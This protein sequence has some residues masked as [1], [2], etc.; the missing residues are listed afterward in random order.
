MS[1]LIY[2]LVIAY[3]LLSG[4]ALLAQSYSVRGTFFDKKT[5][6]V[7]PG[8]SVSILN[9]TDS[10]IVKGVS[11]DLNGQF[12]IQEVYP[13]AYILK[14][15]LIGLSP[16]YRS[17]QISSNNLTIGSIYLEL[18]ETQ[19]KTV[20]IEGTEIRV[21]QKGDTTEINAAAYQV[22]PDASVED[23]IKKMPG[24]TV[25]NGVVKAQGEEVKK[26]LI[27]G[28]EYFG[29]DA[30]S[31]VKNLPA[32]IVE[33]MQVFDK[34]SDQAQ[35]T[36]F[37][38]GNSLKTMNIVTKVGKRNGKFGKQTAGYGTNDRFATSFTY[39]A[40]KKTRKISVLGM[41]N[42]INQ[43]NFSS[44]DL[45]GVTSAAGSGGGGR[46]G[47]GG[48]VGPPTND[49]S[50]FSV[51][52]SNGINTTSS[53]GFNYNDSLN[54]YIKLTGSYFFNSTFNSTRKAINR[55][56][57]LDSSASQTYSEI[58]NGRANNL[59]HRVNLRVEF[60]LDSS[61]T[62]IF[63]PKVSWQGNQL[64]SSVTG[65]SK[66]SSGVHLS[67]TLNDN[68]KINSGYTVNTNLLFRHKFR[69]AGRTISLNTG[70]DASEKSGNNQLNSANEY[71]AQDTSGAQDSLQRIRQLSNTESR[72]RNFNAG[73]VYSEP[74]GK[75]MQIMLT[76][77]PSYSINNAKK[78]TNQYDTA[79]G[80]YTLFD[81]LLSNQFKNPI[82]TQRGGAGIR[83]NKKKVMMMITANFQEVRLSSDQTFPTSLSLNRTFMNFLPMAMFNFKFNKG[84]N[85]R[86]FYR[87]STNVPSVNQLQNVVDNSNPLQLTSGNQQLNQ[88][89]SQNLMIRFGTTDPVSG[90]SVFAS[91]RSSLINQYIGNSSLLA[92]TDTILPD[93][94]RLRTGSQLTKPVN[95]NGYQNLATLLTL[96]L[97]SKTLKS[98]FN[99]Q[100]GLN[101]SK[102]PGLI[103]GILNK[104]INYGLSGGLVIAS[105]INEKIDFTLSYN[106]GWNKVD[107]TLQ[108]TLNNNYITQTASIK[109]NWLP[110]KGLVLNTELTHNRYDGLAA[111]FNQ[112]FVLWNA[113]I[114]YKFLKNKAA[115]IRVS[116]FDL[117]NQ[118]RSIS[119]AVTETYIEDNS[120]KVLNRYFMLTFTYNL[121]KF[122]GGMKAPELAP[123][124]PGSGM[125]PNHPPH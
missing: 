124:S 32:E 17:I 30:S 109:G 50:N 42:N 20:T 84:T 86:M 12:T 94:T 38:D 41:S 103:N 65:E 7:L 54:R 73:L 104:T 125:P 105:N 18:S 88:E 95:M 91:V 15:S 106:G 123:D 89:L 58:N 26:V 115:D 74:L 33:K 72:N 47:G 107:N 102:T 37:D 76:Y 78:L 113:A 53:L 96:S 2:R 5:N 70:I 81:S 114:G 112:R 79:T 63:T 16:F 28:K 120:T 19:L 49:A 51:G 57:F 67:S 27:D 69:K 44:Q 14:A 119:R 21:Q 75:S 23:L 55:I 101:Y 62:L 100:G 61:N 10:S 87:T 99:V 24:I 4:S 64:G 36:G 90:R 98:N 59:N 52:Q 66:R 111:S 60:T 77:S 1:K 108:P 71:Y 29:D 45:L 46:M 35:F 34:M 6:E 121:R 116:A 39:N 22:N 43:Q 97:P 11:A 56:Y 82:L 9:T 25:E 110:W 48:M 40:F 93:G 92:Q 117:L 118:N 8:I 13:G 122:S 83:F 31:A 3:F 85:L 68:T 80:N